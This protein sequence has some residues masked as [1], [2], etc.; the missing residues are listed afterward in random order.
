MRKQKGFSLIEL[1]I[2]VAI[3][4][5]IAA[6]AIPSLLRSKIAAQDASAVASVRTIVTGQATYA[7][8]YTDQGFTALANLGQPVAPATPDST[9]AGLIDDVLASGNKSGFTFASSG[10]GGDAAATPP[11]P[12]SKFTA[13]A[14][15]NSDA[16]GSRIFCTNEQGV[17]RF[18]PYVA[19]DAASKCD[20]ATSKIL[21]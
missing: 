1:L 11:V 2:V 18:E 6:I 12:N 5:I 9:K 3:I 16:T 19:A 10:S 20:A 7:S 21:Q 17:I 14:L 15:P 8:S 4:L 13:S